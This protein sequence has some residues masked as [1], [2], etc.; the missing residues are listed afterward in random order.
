[1]SATRV[2]SY[3][4]CVE[5][6]YICVRHASFMNPLIHL[7]LLRVVTGLSCFLCLIAGNIQSRKHCALPSKSPC[8]Q[9]DLCTPNYPL[10]VIQSL[11]TIVWLFLSLDTKYAVEKQT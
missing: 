10:S 6:S 5:C 8:L 1:M 9:Q 3:K 7:W 11:Y 2:D 4:R